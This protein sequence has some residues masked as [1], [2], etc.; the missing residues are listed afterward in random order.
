[1]NQ[2]KKKKHHSL[3]LQNHVNKYGIDDLEFSIIKEVDISEN[4]I[5]IEQYYLDMFHPKF[6]VCAIAGTPSVI[7][8]S[9]ESYK[10]SAAKMKGH[11]FWGIRVQSDELKEKISKSKL[12]SHC[13]EA[14]R[15]KISLGI[16]GKGKIQ[17]HMEYIKKNIKYKSQ[18]KLANELN[19]SQSG[20]SRML[21]QCA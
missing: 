21:K 8:R 5:E 1:M 13:S 19:I 11:E 18:A 15:K 3:V 9:K 16:Q 2:L 7:S 17:K 4:L 10:R 14:T 20:I 12:G 6:N